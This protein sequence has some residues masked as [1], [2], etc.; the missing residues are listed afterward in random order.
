L[1]YRAAS[2]Q[3]IAI[4]VVVSMMDYVSSVLREKYV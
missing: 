2:A 4:A 1:N 3:M